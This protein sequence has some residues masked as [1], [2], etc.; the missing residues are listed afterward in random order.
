MKVY[1]ITEGE[2]SDYHIIGVA[3]SREKAKRISNM[4]EG[5]FSLPNIEEYDTDFW[6]KDDRQAYCVRVN[7]EGKISIGRLW[8]DEPIGIV[9][10]RRD[11]ITGKIDGYS[12]IVYA[13]DEKHA[14]K[15]A[16]D[17]IAEFKARKEGI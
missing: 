4:F 16:Q 15:I 10:E 8:H 17:K 13:K 11:W 3:E 7:A 14:F 2:Y 6:V 9:T 12:V 1:V 5:S